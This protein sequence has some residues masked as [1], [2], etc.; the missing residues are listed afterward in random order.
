V[1][2]LVTDSDRA[3]AERTLALIPADIPQPQVGHPGDGMA[4]AIASLLAALRIAGWAGE[5]RGI[6]P[7]RPGI[8]DSAAGFTISPCLAARARSISLVYPRGML[9]RSRGRQESHPRG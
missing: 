7:G 9:Q 6:D 1:L 3:L 5:A 2:A 8:P 4:P